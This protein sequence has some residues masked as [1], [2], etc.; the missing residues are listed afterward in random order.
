MDTIPD[1]IRCYMALWSEDNAEIRRQLLERCWA[2]DGTIEIETRRLVGRAG[3]EAEVAWFKSERSTDRAEL[4]SDIDQV[5]NWVRYTARVVR[6]DGTHYSDV[7]DV[8]ELDGEG[9]IKRLLTFRAP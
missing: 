2:E 8:F 3:V 5:G 1:A 4:T 6:P 9:R 7:L